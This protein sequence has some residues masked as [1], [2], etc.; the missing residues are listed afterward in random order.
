MKIKNI[1]G[2]I[3]DIDL[4]INDLPYHDLN[5][6]EQ[7]VWERIHKYFKFHPTHILSGEL[8]EKVVLGVML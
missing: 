8:L 7:I 4:D 2:D 3:V 6:K 1:N 5:E